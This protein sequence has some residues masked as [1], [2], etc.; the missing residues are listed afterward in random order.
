VISEYPFPGK[1]HRKRAVVTACLLMLALCAGRTPN[2]YAC[3]SVLVSS[4][5]ST[6]GSVFISWT[7]DVA[8]FM[9]PLPFYTGGTYAE[10]DSL[11]LYSF[12]EKKHLG[13]ISQVPRTFKVVGNMNEKQVSIG[14]TTFTGRKDLGGGNGLFDYGN[15]IYI[16]L[17]RAGSAREAI[18]IMDELVKEYGYRDTGE[19]FSIAD[20][21]EAWIV[22]F[23]GK[24]EHGKGALWVAARVPDGYIAAHANQARIRKINWKDTENWMWS[25]DVVDFARRMGWFSG[26]DDDFSFAD[27][28][29]PV[30]PRSLLLCESRV[31]SIFNRA[32]PS[33]KFSTDY[34]R[35]VE[36]AEPYPLFIRPDKKLGI[37]D[38]IALHRDHFHNTPFYTGEGTAAG[39]YANPYRW[40]PVFFK[41]EGDTN[42][43]AWERPI[44]QPQT[45]FSY[46]SQARSGLPDAIGGI[47]WYSVDDNFSNVWMPFYMA[48]NQVPASLKGGSPVKFSWKSMYWVVSLVNNFAYGMYNVM[49]EDILEVQRELESR[50]VSM[51]PAIDRAAGYLHS[52]N[53]RLME[54]YLTSFCV[55]NAEQ[56]TERWRELAEHLF[57]KYNDRYQRKEMRIDSWPGSIGYPEAFNRRAVE[58][59]PGYYDVRWRKKRE[60]ID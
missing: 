32:A 17:Q 10:G 25:A 50:A 7:Y 20:K 29:A 3:T 15:L 60:K 45:A 42:D 18:R 24:G 21:N 16:T 36:G 30:T 39:P 31:W 19:S 37:E 26:S 33:K 35:C 5:A 52:S 47:A 41:L 40:R 11:E 58:E 9:A 43:Y 48:M 14:E 12:R 2:V 49:I 6:D 8:G 54:D 59:R 56:I 13:R 44:S 1:I 27:A 22:D 53:P 51:I 23:I 28:Y 34:W 4:G 55:D 38:V 57:V 46:I